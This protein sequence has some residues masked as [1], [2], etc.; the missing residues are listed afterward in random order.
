MY[1]K[2]LNLPS[3]MKKRGLIVQIYMLILVSIFLING[4]TATLQYFIS[5]ARLDENL[6]IRADEV[7]EE[8]IS[9]IKEYPAYTWLLKYWAGHAKEMD[10]EY[11]VDFAEGT[12]TEEKS[13]LLTERHP[14]LQLRYCTEQELEALPGEDQKLYAE[15]V[16][17]WLITRMNAIKKTFGCDYLYLV[18]TDTEEGPDPYAT[19]VFLLSAAGSG[20]VRGTAYEEAYTLGVAVSVAGNKALQDAMREAV[21]VYDTSGNDIISKYSFSKKLKDSGNYLDFYACLERIGDKAVL[22]GSTYSAEALLS[23]LQA[24]VRKDTGISIVH[25]LI[26]L[27]LVI[28]FILVYM[29]NPLNRILKMIRSYTDRKDSKVVAESLNDI[30][31]DRRSSVIRRN[32]IG[33]LAE[34]FVALTKEIDEYAEQIEKTAAEKERLV[35]EL[36]TAAQI[37]Q[38]MLPDAAPQFPDHP[39]FELCASMT[40][41]RQVGGDFYDYFLTDDHHLAL[42][43][44]DV[45]DKGI[46]AALFMAGSKALIKSRAQA[47]DEPAKILTH[48]NNQ[49]NETNGGKCFVTVW[50][51]IIDL[52][53]GEGTA[54]NAG[55]EHPALCRKGG[56]FELVKYK[57]DLVVGMI[58]DI[59]YRQHTFQLNPGD[60][61]YVYTDGVPEAGNEAN[62]QFGTGR[63][64]EVLNRSR[65][66]SP[67][68]MLAAV[69]EEIN[70]FMG[71]ASRFDDTTMMCFYY[72][73][74]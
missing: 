49:L 53:T 24:S 67:K 57:H 74:E 36:E 34:D 10:V 63:M 50:L 21:E 47:G 45:S 3:V 20:L 19:Q 29:L 1:I 54:A 31:T 6:S 15:I 60:R 39:E 17:S 2:K 42:V 18:M 64:L 4:T 14:E 38:Q 61:L 25:Q 69:G 26:M 32:E 43:I 28:G 51:A 73:G 44:A 65:E 71:E 13:S 58:R 7:S 16:Y 70:A 37:Q 30:L 68:E 11:D 12:V 27:N 40:P 72:K 5:R 41:A 59:S 9:S 56:S 66:R 23:Q 62:E 46:P 22:T 33:Q 48:V 35:F 52:R 55:H 8:V